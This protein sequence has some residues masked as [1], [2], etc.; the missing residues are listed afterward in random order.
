MEQVVY[1]CSHWH[2]SCLHGSRRFEPEV[3]WL[4]GWFDE[5][6]YCPNFLDERLR[7]HVTY[8]L[9]HI[10]L[11]YYSGKVKH[12]PYTEYLDVLYHCFPNGSS[13]LLSLNPLEGDIT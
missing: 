3:C 4:F 13:S 7:P 6:R 8:S 10:Q 11:Q 2:F 12:R 1:V 9:R 5:G